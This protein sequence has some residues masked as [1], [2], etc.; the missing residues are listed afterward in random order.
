MTHPIAGMMALPNWFV[1]SLI[2]DAVEGKFKKKPLMHSGFDT[3]D[4]ILETFDAARERVTAL[5]ATGGKYTLGFYFTEGCGYWFLDVDHCLTPDRTAL[6]PIAAELDERFAGAAREW[7]TSGEGLHYF[8]RGN[9][10]KIGRKTG[11]IEFYTWGRGV[12]FGPVF[13]FQGVSA[14]LDF[15]EQVQWLIARFNLA[16]PTDASGER[17]EWRGSPIEGWSGPDDDAELLRQFVLEPVRQSR[18]AA[19]VFGDHDDTRISNVNLWSGNAAA[20]AGCY[21]PDKPG[22]PYDRSKADFALALRLAYW[23]GKDCPRVERL[24]Q[25]SP[26][27][28]D[29]WFEQWGS[30]WNRNQ[31]DIISACGKLT[32]VRRALMPDA[33]GVPAVVLEHAEAD[34]YDDL[35]DRIAGAENAPVLLDVARTIAQTTG[36]VPTLRK[37]LAAAVNQRS[38]ELLGNA[39][40]WGGAHCDDLCRLQTASSVTDRQ[41]AQ[42]ELNKALNLSDAIEVLVPR[43]SVNDMLAD[44]VYIAKGKMVGNLRD[45]NSVYKIDEFH[46]KFAASSIEGGTPGAKPAKVSAIWEDDD[47]RI[48]VDTRTFRAGADIITT[49]PDNVKALNLWRPIIRGPG[50]VDVSAFVEHITYLFGDDADAFLDWLA[51]IEQRPGVLPHYGWLHIADHHGCGRNWVASVLSRLWRGYVA[52]S[53]DI[54][55]LI[56]GNYNGEIAG[57]VLAI[58]DEVREGGNE[59]AHAIEGKIR[60]LLTQET[61]HINPKY[62]MQYSEVNSC[63]WLL[64]SNHRNAIPMGEQDRRW[65][66]VMKSDKPL[67]PLRYVR[68]YGLLDTPGFVE[69]VGVLLRNRDISKFN[70]GAKPPSNAAKLRAVEAS[71]SEHRAWADRIAR[72]WPCDFISASDVEVIMSEGQDGVKLPRNAV[73]RAMNDAGLFTR[74]NAVKLKGGKFM[75]VWTVRNVELWDANAMGH[76]A[77]DEIEKVQREFGVSAY[78]MLNNLM[79]GG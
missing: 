77:A 61:R 24:M 39:K 28:R 56:T 9:V 16:V 74:A 68:L 11:G 10:P 79:N 7:S 23:T 70:P 8:G 49:D 53:V 48:T 33:E 57:R 72:Y 44:M 3:Q 38:K 59:N 46:A 5:R 36:I 52:P 12:A 20:I 34:G 21:P 18:S 47:R 65:W 55:S 50:T 69:S 54:A 64:F 37:T 14:D 60:Q 17:G 35:Q 40:G 30:G 29:R 75:R 51:H 78:A 4:A 22:E 15:T 2:W 45:R 27:K 31:H 76:S 26:L 62:G 19:I 63:R 66:V 25:M 73:R 13:E 67:H 58:V 71:K 43:M 41:Q 1:Y 6:T 32:S 42:R